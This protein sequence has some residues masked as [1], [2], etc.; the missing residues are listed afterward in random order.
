MPKLKPAYD[1][2]EKYRVLVNEKMA[3]QHMTRADLAYKLGCHRTTLSTYL[4][5]PEKLTLGLIRKINRH[6]GITAEDARAALPMV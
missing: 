2:Y 4:D 1:P 5:N 6:L 3:T